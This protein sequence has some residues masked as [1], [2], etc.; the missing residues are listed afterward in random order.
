MGRPTKL[1]EQTHEAI[2]TAVRAG[3]YVETAAQAAGISERTFY[4][5]MERGEADYES[6]LD[7]PFSQ[8]FQAVE[9]AKA[10]SEKIDLDLIAKAAGEG[11]WQAAAW[12]LERRFKDKWG[13]NDKMKIEHAGSIGRDVEVLT[14][15]QLDQLEAKLTGPPET[16]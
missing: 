7:S 8:F 16:S 2:V 3:N 13:R 1:N 10:E 4:H 12:R 14:D 15:E 6:D 5:W 11:N 9:K